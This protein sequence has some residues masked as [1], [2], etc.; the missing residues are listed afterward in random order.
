METVVLV[1]WRESDA[2][3]AWNYEIARPYLERLGMRIFEGDSD[4]AW[5]RGAAVNRAAEDAGTWDVAVIADADTITQAEAVHAAVSH[6]RRTRAAARPHR[7]RHMLTA[8]G[9]YA[10]GYYGPEAL[11]PGDTWNMHRG[12][13]TLVVHRAA[14]EAVG[15]YDP[16]YSGW[17]HEDT[18]LNVRLLAAAG[19]DMLDRP[20]WHLWHPEPDKRAAYENRRRMVALMR[21]HGDLLRRESRARGYVIQQWL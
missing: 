1:P 18:D 3:R 15:G 9:S 2:L 8:G 16:A 13:G 19:W 20:A 11:G 12:G 17:G 5:S 10:L 6:V 21:A 14:W 7:G 4:G